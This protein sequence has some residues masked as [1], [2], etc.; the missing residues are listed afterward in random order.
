LHLFIAAEEPRVVEVWEG[1]SVEGRDIVFFVL[2]L[3]E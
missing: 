2:R 1:K 3:R